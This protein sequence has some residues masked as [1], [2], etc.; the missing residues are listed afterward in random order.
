[1][2][3][4]REK[5]ISNFG[6]WSPWS[7]QMLTVSKHLYIL[8]S[9]P[10]SVS[11]CPFPTFST[12]IGKLATCQ[13]T[14]WHDDRDV[15]HYSQSKNTTT[16]NL[17]SLSQRKPQNLMKTW[18]YHTITPQARYLLWLYFLY[19]LARPWLKSGLYKY[20]CCRQEEKN[21]L[22]LHNFQMQ[23]LTTSYMQSSEK[24]Y[25][26]GIMYNRGILLPTPLTRE[27]EK[28]WCLLE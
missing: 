19:H 25:R 16:A 7:P 22:L 8:K 4:C 5:A 21:I 1:M 24:H 15:L 27:R 6:Q 14:Q 20:S 28:R 10:A 17:N 9:C 26:R 3:V 12:Q 23:V 18:Q 2:E 13:Q 11:H